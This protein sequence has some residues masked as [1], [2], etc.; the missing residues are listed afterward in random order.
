MEGGEIGEVTC[1][2]GGSG[3]G[4][5][6]GVFWFVNLGGGGFTPPPPPPIM[7]KCDQIKMRENMDRR[8]TTPKRLPH[9]WGCLTSI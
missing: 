1:G 9:L 4:G 7:Y 5:G 8:V 6:G 3:G 2:G